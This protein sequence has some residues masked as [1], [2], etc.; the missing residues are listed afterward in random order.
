MLPVLQHPRCFNCH[1]GVNPFKDPNVGHHMGGQL[2]VGSGPG[3]CEDCHA[4][5]TNWDT[6]GEPMLF[7]GKGARELC[8]QFKEF[9]PTAASFI[10]HMTNDN[11]GIQFLETAYKGLRALN[12]LGET[13]YEDET[14]R[15]LTAEKPPGTHA[16]LIRDA[17]AWANAVGRGWSVKPDC[18]CKVRGKAWVGTVTQSALGSLD[19]GLEFSESATANVRFEIDASFQT[20]LKAQYW[21]AVSGT[22]SWAQKVAG[23]CQMSASG[24]LPIGRGSD[25]NPMARL[26]G[27]PGA[28]GS[29]KFSAS[30]GPWPDVYEP[31]GNIKCPDDPKTQHPFATGTVTEWWN[32][33]P[34]GMGS[35]DGKVLKGSYQAVMGAAHVKWTWD[36]HAEP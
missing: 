7:V 3:S 10:G 35:P 31:Q 25:G 24:T 15:P 27:V 11:N 33:D 16:D 14:G 34:D 1:G 19:G 12:T 21:A 18:G 22:I 8:I 5:L 20:S 32:Y 4:G 26:R 36:L 30:I 23:K 29:W 13:T 9:E 28:N 17:T 6:P 2:P